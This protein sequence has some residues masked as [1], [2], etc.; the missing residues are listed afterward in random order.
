MLFDLVKGCGQVSLT[1]VELVVL[2]ECLFSKI[3]AHIFQ[4]LEK[5]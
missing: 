1:P 4:T 5:S 2:H 3:C